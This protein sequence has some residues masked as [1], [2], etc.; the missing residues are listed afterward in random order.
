VHASRGRPHLPTCRVGRP[1][2]LTTWTTSRHFS[3]TAIW[4]SF[5]IKSDNPVY[6]ASAR[7]SQTGCSTS[8][9]G[10]LHGDAS[11]PL[12]SAQEVQRQIFVKG[13]VGIARISWAYPEIEDA[14]SEPICPLTHR[15]MNIPRYTNPSSAASSYTIPGAFDVYRIQEISFLTT[16]WYVC[17]QLAHGPHN[18]ASTCCYTVCQLRRDRF[19][20]CTMPLAL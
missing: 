12:P 9:M 2:G 8:G 14:A 20:A 7:L 15:E 19:T 5:L 13:I 1:L 17:A 4:R 3:L 16:Q 6:S 10:V 11:F 18:G